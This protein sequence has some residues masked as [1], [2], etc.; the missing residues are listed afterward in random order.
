MMAMG[1]ATRLATPEP[2]APMA[3]VDDEASNPPWWPVVAALALLVV[4]T[5]W[6]VRAQR[7]RR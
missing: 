1:T 5:A 6:T 3:N 7:L 4:G 2:R